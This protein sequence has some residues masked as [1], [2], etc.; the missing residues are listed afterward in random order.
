MFSYHN[1]QGL[2][3]CQFQGCYKRFAFNVEVVFNAE[4]DSLLGKGPE[5]GTQHLVVA[6]PIVTTS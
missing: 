4:S 1:L 3:M 2:R 5:K 6:A